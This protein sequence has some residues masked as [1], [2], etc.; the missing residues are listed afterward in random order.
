MSF[1]KDFYWGG[2][3]ASN[4]CEGAWNTDGKGQSCADHFTAGTVDTPR[5]FTDDIREGLRRLGQFISKIEG[6][7]A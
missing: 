7:R 1:P 6:E 2:A 4:Q 5:M 3:T